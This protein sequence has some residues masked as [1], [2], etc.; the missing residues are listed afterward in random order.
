MHPKI[1]PR[2]H[3][4]KV[5]NLGRRNAKPEIRDQ[6]PEILQTLNLTM[7]M[8]KGLAVTVLYALFPPRPSV[9]NKETLHARN[10]TVREGETERSRVCVVPGGNVQGNLVHKKTPTP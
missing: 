9:F 2:H 3:N 1:Q 10:L 5:S 6:I 7:T 4:K 8:R